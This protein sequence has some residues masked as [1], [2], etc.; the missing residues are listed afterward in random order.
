[1]ITQNGSQYASENIFDFMGGSYDSLFALPF[2]SLINNFA[3]NSYT[4]SSIPNTLGGIRASIVNFWTSTT[5]GL[6]GSLFPSFIRISGTLNAY[7]TRNVTS[8][9]VIFDNL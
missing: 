4:I 8:I 1:M 3:S 9:A 7:E 2:G 5:T 6:D